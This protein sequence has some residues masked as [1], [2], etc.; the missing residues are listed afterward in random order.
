MR[1][2]PLRAPNHHALARRTWSTTQV[3]ALSWFYFVA[4]SVGSIIPAVSSNSTTLG[5]SNASDSITSKTLQDPFSYVFPDLVHDPADRFPMPACN[6]MVLEEAT[7]DELQESM[8]RGQLTSVA[9]LMCY[10]QRVYQTDEYIKYAT[11][12]S[13]NQSLL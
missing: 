5:I 8:K 4:T 10:L 9:I 13:S 3:S 1:F 7:I 2:H 11:L 6:G 12:L